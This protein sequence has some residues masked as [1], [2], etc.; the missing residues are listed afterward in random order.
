VKEFDLDA[1]KSVPID[2]VIERLG[3]SYAECATGNPDR[4]RFV[5]H[6]C[7]FGYHNHGDQK[8]S[9][10]IRRATNTAWCPICSGE[11]L[12]GDP[13]QVAKFMKGG[14]KEGCEWL[15]A[16]FNISY[17]SEPS[18]PAKAYRPVSKKPA[19]K[20]EYERFDPSKEYE[21]IDLERAKNDYE[22]LSPAQR[23]KTVYTAIYRESLTTDQSRKIQ[24]YANR[25]I[26][27]HPL[28][29][30]IGFI[31]EELS[32]TIVDR[33]R[34]AQME[35]LQKFNVCNEKGE[36]KYGGGHVC[37]PSFDLD[38]SAI[39][40][41][42]LRPLAPR[43]RA[44]EISVCCPRVYRALPFGLG[45]KTLRKDKPIVITEGHVDALSLPVGT[46]FVAIPGVGSYFVESLGTLRDKR[47]LIA[48]DMDDAGEKGA[49]R[50]KKDLIAAGAT[51][52]I[53]KWDPSL[54]KDIN[55]LLVGGHK[56][57]VM[58]I[59]EERKE[60]SDEPPEF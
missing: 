4:Q 42:V 35:D 48:Y 33:L 3:G 1:L 60:A 54:G 26:V 5:M 55:E 37:A 2:L 9:L 38:S 40:A 15:M 27:N 56:F 32:R 41:L 30:I 22:T 31:D 29:E 49:R 19:F 10:Y 28:L 39:T 36:W 11:G 47:C 58:Q 13:V 21:R 45:R 25:G 8:P 46:S 18:A 17:K 16:N 43:G 51:A 20:I 14:F 24:Y 23:L 6:C 34:F 53:L 57:S 12:S 50:L 59:E 7:N 52:D 44:K